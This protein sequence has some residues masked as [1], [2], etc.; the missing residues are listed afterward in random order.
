M[1]NKSQY[2]HPSIY[3]YDSSTNVFTR[4][5]I[6]QNSAYYIWETGVTRAFPDGFQMIGGYDLQTNGSPRFSAE[7]V[8]P[9][10]STRPA[11]PSSFGAQTFFPLTACDELEANMAFPTCWNGV[12]LSSAN[13]RSHVA[14]ASDD[15][16]CP[17]GFPVALPEIL[18]F[19]RVSPYF[20]GCHVFS[21]MSQV[22][23]AD[24]FSGWEVNFLQNV[25]DKCN[26]TSTS[27]SPNFF[28]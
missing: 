4:E 14:Y 25:L 8:S 9:S 13:G 24:Y 16:I 3:S 27:A 6:F 10:P 5:I 15:G 2:W 26:N 23:H 20:G 17:D 21:D 22:F 1:E 7:C 18:F 19:L 12:D 28:W 11:C